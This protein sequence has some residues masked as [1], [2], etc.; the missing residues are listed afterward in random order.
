[1]LFYLIFRLP[2]GQISFP[3]AQTQHLK[4]VPNDTETETKGQKLRCK[5]NKVLV[6]MKEMSN[7]T[8]I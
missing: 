2:S 8:L 3:F 5:S 7:A 6:R 4:L 1:M